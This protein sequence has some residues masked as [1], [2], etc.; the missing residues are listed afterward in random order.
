M[1]G[2]SIL[3]AD[4]ILKPKQT[5]SWSRSIK[6][7]KNDPLVGK[8]FFTGEKA[9]F[10][11]TNN[12]NLPNTLTAKVYA[13]VEFP[14]VSIILTTAIIIVCCVLAYYLLRFLAPRMIAVASTTM[15]ETCINRCSTSC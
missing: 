5:W 3:D 9:R 7:D 11:I 6:K 12:T 10:Y 2:Y 8:Y 14:Q 1:P 13:N 15:K 4:L